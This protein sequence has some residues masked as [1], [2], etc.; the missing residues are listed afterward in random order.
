M[1]DNLP[2]KTVNPRLC[3][4]PEA[5][6]WVARGGVIWLVTRPYT[7]PA[8]EWERRTVAELVDSD[9]ITKYIFNSGTVYDLR[10]AA[11]TLFSIKS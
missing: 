6:E 5:R 3:R 8:T 1:M 4:I 2:A 11:D 9:L 10:T 7:P